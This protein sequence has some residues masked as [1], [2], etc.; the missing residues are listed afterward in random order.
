MFDP[1]APVAEIESG[2]HDSRATLR[3]V[4]L[5]GKAR[6]ITITTIVCSVDTKLSFGIFFSTFDL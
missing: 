4:M 6:F 3:L 5:T 1:Q 2:T